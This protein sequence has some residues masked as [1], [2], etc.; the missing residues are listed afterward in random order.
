METI[1]FAR[2][3]IVTHVFA[4]HRQHP[5]G[6]EDNDFVVFVEVEDD[7]A[8]EQPDEASEY[9]YVGTLDDMP[10]GY[11][12]LAHRHR[13]GGAH[14]D[15]A[16]T[17]VARNDFIIRATDEVTDLASKPVTHRQA[18]GE[19]LKVPVRKA[20]IEVRPISDAE[21]G[22]RM[23]AAFRSAMAQL[24]AFDY[25]RFSGQAEGQRKQSAMAVDMTYIQIRAICILAM[26]I[27]RGIFAQWTHRDTSPADIRILLKHLETTYQDIQ[28]ILDRNFELPVMNRR[29]WMEAN[30]N[31]FP[32]D[33]MTTGGVEVEPP[34][35][36]IIESIERKGLPKG[37]QRQP[38][39]R[40]D[41]A[42]PIETWPAANSVA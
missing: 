3:V 12:G 41:P 11:D 24:R 10:Q 6:Q 22:A 18:G 20:T 37:W 36:V 16:F 23:S 17:G 38:F 32:T 30:M 9:L 4:H 8:F 1:R 31:K 40:F 14:N 26:S 2:S 13:S 35:G 15:S 42:R 29:A 21:L 7:E 27:Q 28:A 25:R 19:I 39:L 5:D 34:N 33:I